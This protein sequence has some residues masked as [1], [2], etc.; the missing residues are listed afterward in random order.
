[1]ISLKGLYIAF[2]KLIVSRPV[3][4]AIKM[5]AILKKVSIL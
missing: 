4:K 2:P 1:M 5:D 3:L